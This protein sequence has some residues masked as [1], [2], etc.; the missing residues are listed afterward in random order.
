MKSLREVGCQ[1]VELN[2]AERR[3]YFGETDDTLSLKCAAA[4][5]NH[6]VPLICI[7]EQ[8]ET[9]PEEA[10]ESLK[11]QLDIIF[12]AIPPSEPL[13]LA[14][15]PVWAIGAPRPAPSSYIVAVGKGL[16]SLLS[17]AGR[18]ETAKVLYGGSA[19]PGLCGDIKEGMDGMF[20]GRFA[21]Q[22]GN[23]ER[24]MDEMKTTKAV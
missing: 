14:Y 19:G 6:L 20:L 24:I 11:Q 22:I 23:V 7:G 2:H 8:D 17:K 18:G 1:V 15:E 10:L 9:S 3:K 5:R 16:K 21:H 4:V 13:M 12:R